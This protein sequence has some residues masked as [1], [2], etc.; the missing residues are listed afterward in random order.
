MYPY[1]RCSRHPVF[2]IGR[3]ITMFIGGIF[4]AGIFGFMFGWLV[5]LLWNWLMPHLFHLPIITFWQS[6]GLVIL[7]K[8][9]FG[10]MHGAHDHA[11]AHRMR[12]HRRWKKEFKDNFRDAFDD[13]W[14]PDGD[15]RNWMFYRTYWKEKGK[16]DFEDYLKNRG[17]AR[18]TT[19]D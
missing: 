12:E 18:D 7:A 9:L 1:S 14:L 15:Y 6:F 11:R 10:G 5:M 8:L 17:N 4:V 3:I 13:E 19:S 2:S 16:K